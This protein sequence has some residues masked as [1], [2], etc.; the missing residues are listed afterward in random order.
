MR[1]A[2]NKPNLHVTEPEHDEEGGDQTKPASNGAGW[3]QMRRA[4][5]KPNLQVMELGGAR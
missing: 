3:I 4:G 2:G 5:T 1:R